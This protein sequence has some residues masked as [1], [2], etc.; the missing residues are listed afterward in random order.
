M[1]AKSKNILTKEIV[2]NGVKY[3]YRYNVKTNEWSVKR[4]FVETGYI[5]I[6]RK[7]TAIRV[8]P[9]LRR[10]AFLYG[11][12]LPV[13]GPQPAPPGYK[14]LP[15]YGPQPAPPGYKPPL[16]VYGPE[17]APPGYVAPPPL[18]GPLRQNGTY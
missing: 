3:K 5:P 16:P 7:P 12:H 11:P 6:K 9:R 8:K 4:T 14:P 1:T 18:Y 2:K 13:Y 15:V 17:P 10:A